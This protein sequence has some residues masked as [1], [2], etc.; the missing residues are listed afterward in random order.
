MQPFNIKNHTFANMNLIEFIGTGGGSIVAREVCSL[1]FKM[2]RWKKRVPSRSII[3]VTDIYENLKLVLDNTV[4]C[5]V[6]IAKIEDSGGP[7]IPGA[8]VFVSV[9]NED[10]TK[11]QK[12][13]TELFQRWRADKSYIEILR[14]VCEQGSAKVDIS[15]IPDESTLRSVY[16]TG[17]ITHTEAYFIAQTKVKLF[18]ATISTTE[19]NGFPTADRYHIEL[20]VNRLRKVF[21]EYYA[22]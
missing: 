16:E 19:P 11:P 22:N 7:L 10:Y 1:L 20:A 14:S 8:D 17:G 13:I 3:K 2:W 21:K 12:P 15:K 4:A 5:R 9:I 18:I 6:T